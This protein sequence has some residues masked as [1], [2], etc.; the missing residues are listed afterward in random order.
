MW[1]NSY[2]KR[3][4]KYRTIEGRQMSSATVCQVPQNAGNHFVKWI[5]GSYLGKLYSWHLFFRSVAFFSLFL[6][7]S[8]K[9]LQQQQRTALSPPEKNALLRKYQRYF[10]LTI[11][12]FRYMT[13]KYNKL[14][15]SAPFDL[16]LTDTFDSFW[17]SQSANDRSW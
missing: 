3:W 8:I 14:T 6:K 17:F 11:L 1:Q 15:L 5:A 2:N 7:P 13:N 4:S 16:L 12:S 10:K 9:K